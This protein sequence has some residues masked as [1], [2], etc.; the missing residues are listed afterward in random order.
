MK[1]A[2]IN[3]Q[4][5]FLITGSMKMRIKLS[6]FIVMLLMFCP[7]TY[8]KAQV[9]VS[10]GIG[11]PNLSVEI[12]LPMYPTLAPVPGYTWSQFQSSRT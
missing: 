9:S 7:A 3:R 1:P 10:I 5:A 2:A 8:A 11:L 6:G 12:N 4:R